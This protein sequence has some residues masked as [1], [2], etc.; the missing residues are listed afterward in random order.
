[1]IEQPANLAAVHMSASV[2]IFGC[3]PHATMSLAPA[4]GVRKSPKEE[5]AGKGYVCVATRYNGA[6]AAAFGRQ[7]GH[8]FNDV[9]RV[10]LNGDLMFR[11]VS[12]FK[13]LRVAKIAHPTTLA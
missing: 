8:N 3:R 9:A 11:L 2:K 5:T 4:A 10:L 12:D 6:L 7:R 1:V 13:E